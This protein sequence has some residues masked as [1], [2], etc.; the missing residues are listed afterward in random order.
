MPFL[1][2]VEHVIW[3]RAIVRVDNPLE[4]PQ[5]RSRVYDEKRSFVGVV[6]DVIGSV[7]KPY[8]VV[9]LRDK[10]ITLSKGSRLFYE[11]TVKRRRR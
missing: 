1:G 9:S 3:G 11:K 4:I 6:V 10:S 7:S 8:A 2:L 5:L